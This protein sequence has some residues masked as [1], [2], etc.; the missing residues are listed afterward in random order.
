MNTIT[1]LFFATLRDIA[2]SKQIQLDVDPDLNVSGLKAVL[3]GQYPAMEPALRSVLVSVNKE[4]TF[5]KEPVPA[6]A[7][8]ALFPPVSGG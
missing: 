6:G 1:V 8:V 2:G 3:A 5:D 4:Y 7:E